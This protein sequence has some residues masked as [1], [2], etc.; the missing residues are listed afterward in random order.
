MSTTLAASLVIA[1]AMVTSTL[2]STNWPQPHQSPVRKIDRIENHG[3][4]S[5][6]LEK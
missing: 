2:A 5:R 4:S 3:I 1:L 6:S